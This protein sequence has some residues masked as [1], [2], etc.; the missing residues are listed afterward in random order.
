MWLVAVY[1][2]SCTGNCVVCGSNTAMNY[3]EL[4]E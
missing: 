4:M 3:N 2:V 1:T